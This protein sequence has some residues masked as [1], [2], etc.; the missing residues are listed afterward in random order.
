MVQDTNIHSFHQRIKDTS[1]KQESK[2][3]LHHVGGTIELR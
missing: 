2:L 3:P 1:M